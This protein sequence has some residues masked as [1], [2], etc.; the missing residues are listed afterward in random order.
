MMAHGEIEGS[1]LSLNGALVASPIFAT[2]PSYAALLFFLVVRHCDL[3]HCLL[4]PKDE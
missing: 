3:F 2:K 4:L 1:D